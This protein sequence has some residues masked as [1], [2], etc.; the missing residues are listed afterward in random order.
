MVLEALVV[1]L[2]DPCSER[3]SLHVHLTRS[4]RTASVRWQDVMTNVDVFC[5]QLLNNNFSDT[6]TSTMKKVLDRVDLMICSIDRSGEVISCSKFLDQLKKFVDEAGS[7][8]VVQLLPNLPSSVKK[9]ES[10]ARDV[11][12]STEQC[13]GKYFS[14]KSV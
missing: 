11:L 9:W 6:L 4:A 13:S 14:S 5:V 8:S 10:P 1:L 12:G 7:S 2:Q 3:L